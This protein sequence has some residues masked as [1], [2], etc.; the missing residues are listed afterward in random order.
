MNAYS[1]MGGYALNSTALNAHKEYRNATQ[2]KL[3]TTFLPA[4]AAAGLAVVFAVGVIDGWNSIGKI[5]SSATDV[6]HD[7]S[8]RNDDFSKF[9]N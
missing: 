6:N 3:P 9:D 1:A 5:A 7:L 4:L 8:Y 2:N